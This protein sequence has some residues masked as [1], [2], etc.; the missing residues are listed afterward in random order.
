MRV[1]T[2]VEGQQVKTWGDADT[3]KADQTV[4]NFID[5]ANN[6]R[7]TEYRPQLKVADLGPPVLKLTFKDARGGVLGT[8]VLYK[9]DKPAEIAPNADIDP[10]NPPAGEVEYLI[11][12]EKTRVPALVRRDTAERTEQDIATVFSD[13]PTASEP[14]PSPAGAAPPRSPHDSPHGAA[15]APSGA[16]AGAASSPAPGKPSASPAPAPVGH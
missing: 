6:L 16:P 1:Q 14:N 2:G 12:T 13:H 10:A 4:A 5:N 7:P 11:V 15:P 9:H 3:K 8:E